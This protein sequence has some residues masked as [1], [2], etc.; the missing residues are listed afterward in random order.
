MT[1]YGKPQRETVIA[2]FRRASGLVTELQSQPGMSKLPRTRTPM[3]QVPAI[4]TTQTKPQI[5]RGRS[6]LRDE[7][8]QQLAAARARPPRPARPLLITSGPKFNDPV[9]GTGPGQTIPGA[10]KLK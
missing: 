5:N 3:Q 8:E 7:L 10:K 4:P 1:D 6:P 2:P 9:E